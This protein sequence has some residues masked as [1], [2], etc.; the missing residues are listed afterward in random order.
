[1]NELKHLRQL[2]HSSDISRREFIRR[3]AALGVGAS[4]AG[5]LLAESALADTPRKGGTLKL[6]MTGGDTSNSVD[7][8]LALDNVPRNVCY[9]TY[10]TLVELTPES[11]PAPSLAE[12]WEAKP[13]AAEWIF[14][15]RKGVE[16]HNGKT[17]EA[18]DVVH[19]ITRHLA[20]DSKSPVKGFLGGIEELKA[21]TSHQVVMKLKGANADLPYIF[22][23]FH[24]GI[25]PEG[26]EDWEH[27][28]GAGGY[29][30]TEFEPGVRVV[31]ERNPNYWKE[32]R[33]HVD[34]YEITVISD[35]TAR[36]NALR[37]DQVHVINDVDRKTAGLLDE[38]AGLSVVTTAGRKHY[39]NAMNC[40][41]APFDDNNVRL[42]VKYAVNRGQVVEQVFR[43]FGRL[44]ND[45]PIPESDPFH[46]SELPQREYDPNKARW[47]LKQAGLDSLALT[48]HTSPEAV[49]PEA[50]DTALLFKEAI[51]ATGFMTL[52]VVRAPGDGYWSNV[53]RKR[54]FV[55]SYWT[56]RP[57][58]DMIFTQGYASTAKW[59]DTY[60]RREDFDQLLVQARA[61]LDFQKRK[62]LYWEM[63][64]MVY[65]D[66][67]QL[68]HAFADL[69]DAHGSELRGFVPDPSWGL[70]GSRLIE[71]C[72]LA[73]A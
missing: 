37:T 63:Q 67:G 35:T 59:N 14:N 26:F 71:R 1:M 60:W 12:S 29:K 3:A 39:T 36:V 45:H 19:S 55:M 65:N 42:A 70:S 25:I 43:G 62:R 5:A 21:A 15:L 41:Q 31:G 17:L 22:T 72:W 61:E 50:L 27:P 53:W 66:G 23:D 28:V 33:A 58:P 6:G 69:L 49:G 51:D 8:M 32:G 10:D 56:G 9:A 38:V 73:S 18:N 52:D 4:V 47:H 13:G 7:P 2:V 48:L 24:V 54:P 11:E 46:H 30:L 64:E 68:I 57:T 40:T 34:A 44:G 20:P 16:F